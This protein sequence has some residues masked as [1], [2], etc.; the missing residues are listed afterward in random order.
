MFKDNFL[1]HKWKFSIFWKS[2]TAPAYKTN[3]IILKILILLKTMK[4]DFMTYRHLVSTH[5]FP[6]L[7]AEIIC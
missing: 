7:K 6:V 3:L 1:K 5:I 2:Q 4:L